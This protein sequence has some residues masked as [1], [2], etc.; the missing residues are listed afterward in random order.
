MINPGHLNFWHNMLTNNDDLPFFQF[1]ILSLISRNSVSPY[2]AEL[3]CNTNRLYGFSNPGQAL[4]TEVQDCERRSSTEQPWRSG[5]HVHMTDSQKN[6]ALSGAGRID[7]P[8][9]G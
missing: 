4:D 2:I 5:V 1:L 3:M 6:D 8:P 7:D 9:P